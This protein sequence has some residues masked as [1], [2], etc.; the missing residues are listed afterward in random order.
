MGH[1]IISPK[2]WLLKFAATVLRGLVYLRRGTQRYLRNLPVPPGVVRERLQVPSRDKGRFIGVDLYRPANS[3]SNKLPVIVNWHGSGYVLPSWGEDYEFVH[4]AVKALGCIVLD[5]DYRKAPEYAYP[6]AHDDAE[7]VVGWV[8]SQS[9]RFDVQKVALSGFS[10]GAALALYTGNVY[11][12]DKV[13]AVSCLYPPVNVT[14]PPPEKSHPYEARSGVHLAPGVVSLFNN[15]YVPLLST[16]AEPRFRIGGLETSRFPNHIFAATGDIDILHDD[17]KKFF[18]ELAKTEKDKKVTFLTVPRE[19]HAWDK[20]PLVPESV[21]ARDDA[22]R[23]M[24]DNIKASWS[25]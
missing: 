16:R 25:S 24:F 15:S 23:Q 17:A 5:S 1:S 6:S 20:K 11:G 8:L 18:E 10:A 21:K 4:Q 2:Y 3:G 22:Y 7:D 13:G 12:P 19:E 9:Q 14:L